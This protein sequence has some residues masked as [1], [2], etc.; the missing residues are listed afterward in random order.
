MVFLTKQVSSR[1]GLS[2]FYHAEGCSCL[3]RD[4]RNPWKKFLHYP[5]APY[6]C[7]TSKLGGNVAAPAAGRVSHHSLEQRRNTKQCQTE[8]PLLSPL[9]L[10]LLKTPETFIH[11]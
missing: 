3:H 8:P 9:S 11:P 7:Q 5:P 2:V 4:I 6:S 10:S 1:W